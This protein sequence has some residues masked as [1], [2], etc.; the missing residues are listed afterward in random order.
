MTSN[1]PK[2]DALMHSHF[3]QDF[4]LIAETIE[5]LA[6]D[7]KDTSTSEEIVNVRE[8]IAIFLN[9]SDGEIESVFKESYGYDF[10]P[11]LWDLTAKSFL[12]RLNKLLSQD[13]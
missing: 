8:D 1:S 4:N 10:D 3:H 12:Q 11:V 7:F 9:L 6:A 5:G 13:S 2:L